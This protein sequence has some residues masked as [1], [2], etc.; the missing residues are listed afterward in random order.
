MSEEELEQYC[1]D[2]VRQAV[3]KY[4]E[5]TGLEPDL[6][7]LVHIL[8]EAKAEWTR[9]FWQCRIKDKNY[10]QLTKLR[11][12]IDRIKTNAE[13]DPEVR[14]PT[15]TDEPRKVS[16]GTPKARVGKKGAKDLGSKS[17]N[18]RKTS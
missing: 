6:N 12:I 11:E 7:V 9:Q 4:T 16:K 15:K 14:E 5:D 17:S 13:K 1:F 8:D 18:S 3:V 10:K 2:L